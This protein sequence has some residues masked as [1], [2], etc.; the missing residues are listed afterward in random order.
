MLTRPGVR[1][2]AC[3]SSPFSASYFVIWLCFA[4]ILWQLYK[5]SRPTHQVFCRKIRRFRAPNAP[6]L[7]VAGV[8]PATAIPDIPKKP[9]KYGLFCPPI[10]SSTWRCHRQVAVAAPLLPP[11]RSTPWLKIPVFLASSPAAAS[12]DSIRPRDANRSHL[13]PRAVHHLVVRPKIVLRCPKRL[14]KRSAFARARPALFAFQALPTPPES[15][16]I[17]FHVNLVIH[18]LGAERLRTC[19]RRLHPG[20]PHFGKTHSARCRFHGQ[21]PGIIE[22]ISFW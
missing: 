3:F 5:R 8:P 1:H 11:A 22:I 4:A 12:P 9:A 19:F 7:P 6:P 15:P 13:S 2:K 18:P 20:R 16:G 21:L 10:A 14:I 17:L